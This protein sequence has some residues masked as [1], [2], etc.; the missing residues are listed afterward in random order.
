MNLKT[1][2]ENKVSNWIIG[3]AASRAKSQPQPPPPL[4]PHPS[5]LVSLIMDYIYFFPLK[6]SSLTHQVSWNLS[7][8]TARS[9]VTRR[10]P[11]G[12][13]PRG[14]FMGHSQCSWMM[15]PKSQRRKSNT[16]GAGSHSLTTGAVSG[17]TDGK[18]T[19]PP[20]PPHPTHT[21]THTEPPGPPPPPAR[22]RLL[23]SEFTADRRD[24]CSE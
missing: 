14:L 19:P 6:P 15:N 17:E 18:R 4:T 7:P 1:K 24:I 22:L 13:W 23:A 2:T 16:S 9:A 8:A 11:G 21:H 20:T 12:A 3:S 10:A 5:P